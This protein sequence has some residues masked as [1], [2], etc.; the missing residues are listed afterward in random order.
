MIITECFID[1][2][3][4]IIK[5]DVGLIRKGQFPLALVQNAQR[6]VFFKY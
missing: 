3:R 5:A 2:R 1:F 6:F 4:N